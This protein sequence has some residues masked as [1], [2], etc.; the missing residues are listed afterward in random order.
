M[1]I[2][3]YYYSMRT[4]RRAMHVVHVHVFPCVFIVNVTCYI[5]HVFGYITWWWWWWYRVH[6]LR[7]F[8]I[9]VRFIIK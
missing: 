2:P 4:R 6:T 1:V 5:S 7:W 8:L 3:E 9:E